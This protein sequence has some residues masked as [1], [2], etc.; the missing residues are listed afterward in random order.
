MANSLY[1]T[2]T[3]EP[4]LVRYLDDIRKFPMLNAEEERA[5]ARRCRDPGD[6]D[7]A[8]R[9][10]TSHLRLVAKIAM[11]YRGYGLPIGEIM[12][13][14]S[15]GLMR[16]VRRFDAERGYRLATY[17]IHWI[18]A[19]IQDYILRSWSL[20]KMATSANRRKLFY[21]LRRT[22]ARIS[23]LDDDLQP[24]QAAQIASRLQVATPLG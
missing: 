9:L 11:A 13:E 20:V 16:A 8:R 22:K 17:A 21:N 23:A 5:L 24:G 19:A 14:G 12:S 15:V 10:V 18:R 7:A 4:G 6:A 1:S 2:L 3:A